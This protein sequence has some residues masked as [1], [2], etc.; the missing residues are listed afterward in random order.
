M[1]DQVLFL[2]LPMPPHVIIQKIFQDGILLLLYVL[3]TPTGV[4][5][6]VFSSNGIIM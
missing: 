1:V 6:H 4:E 3:V 5:Q 2:D